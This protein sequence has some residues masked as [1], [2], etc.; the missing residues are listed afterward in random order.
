MTEWDPSRLLQ[1]SPRCDLFG[2]IDFSGATDQMPTVVERFRGH[3]SPPVLLLGFLGALLLAACSST[4]PDPVPTGEFTVLDRSVWAGGTVRVRSEDFRQFGDGAA[5]VI[6][7][8]VV[9]LRRLDETTLIG[10]MPSHLAGVVE[11]FLSFDDLGFPLQSVRV[12]GFSEAQE[13]PEAQSWWGVGQLATIAGRPHAIGFQGQDLLLVDLES[14][15]VTTVPQVHA[16]PSAAFS[17]PGPTADPSVWLLDPPGGAVE[18]WSLGAS[19][20]KLALLSAIPSPGTRLVAQLSTSVRLR[21]TASNTI[22]WSSE[23]SPG[24]GYQEL[25]VATW[26]S[27]P[28][29]YGVRLSPRGDRASVRAHNAPDGVPV[30][31]ISQMRIA[32][33]TDLKS[34][35]VVEFS[36]D[37]SEL[38]LVGRGLEQDPEDR[39]SI[40]ERLRASDGVLLA[41]DTVDAKVIAGAYGTDGSWLVLATVPA[42]GTETPPRLLILDPLHFA[43]IGTLDTHLDAHTCASSCWGVIGF[44]QEQM[45]L[46]AG[47]GGGQKIWRYSMQE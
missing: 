40:L 5:L 7:R 44:D 30:F 29:P 25:P 4:D 20:I 24:A 17:V 31:D 16:G 47:F 15:T 21:F 42:D 45:H 6:G 34:S 35:D 33:R 46:F 12:A 32:Y 18:S 39:R 36:P 28:S 26:V 11:P 27:F 37:G 14:G 23:S 19:S 38:L 8:A 41:S 1:G 2:S 9:T 3:C 22:I 43:T 10:T 13:V